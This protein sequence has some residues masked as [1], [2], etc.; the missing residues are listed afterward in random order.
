MDNI[1]DE[2]LKNYEQFKDD[3]EF[4]EFEEFIRQL[5]STQIL[6]LTTESIDPV[7][8]NYNGKTIFYI[9][10]LIKDLKQNIN[11]ELKL[12]Y[13]EKLREDLKKGVDTFIDK[14]IDELSSD[15]SGRTFYISYI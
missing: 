2:T 9:N 4:K 8:K 10:L 7:I 5:T 15:I 13:K 14:Y 3:V 11:K 1:F 12:R 6:N